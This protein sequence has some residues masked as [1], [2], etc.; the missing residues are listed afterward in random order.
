MQNVI[1]VYISKLNKN[2][3]GFFPDFLKEEL[4]T[5][6]NN[7]KI[8]KDNKLIDLY[9][10]IPF[11][12]SKC[13]YCSVISMPMERCRQ[14][15]KPYIVCLKKDILSALDIIAKY[16][17]KLENIYMGGG[18]PTALSAEELEEILMLLPK[19]IDSN[20]LS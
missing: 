17:Y 4:K 19:V 9:I 7:Q 20:L 2:L 8:T 18:T 10:N 6:T 11:C 3:K 1:D 5:I 14:Y 15:V 16:G 12:T 13:Y